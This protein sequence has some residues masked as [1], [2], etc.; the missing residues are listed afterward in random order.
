MVVN[1]WISYFLVFLLHAFFEIFLFSFYW[2]LAMFFFFFFDNTRGISFHFY[3]YSVREK[4]E[5]YFE[6]LE[7]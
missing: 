7:K 1:F 4:N 6:N 5:V 3:F 2:K